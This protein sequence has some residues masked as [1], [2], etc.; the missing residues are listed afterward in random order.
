MAHLSLSLL[1]SF[2]L[3]LDGKPGAGL[4]SNKARALLAYLTVEADRPHRREALAGLLWPD[5]PD[6]DALSNLRYA[7]SNLR[8]VIGDRVRGGSRDAEPPFLLV[9][10]DTLQ[11]NT[12]SDYW[13]D[14]TALT[15]LVEVDKAHPS[16]VDQLQQAVVLYRG[17]FLEGFTVSDSPAF[18]E[19]MLFTRER[20]ARQVSSALHHLAAIYEQRGAY[21]QAQSYAWRQ[22]ELEPWNEAAH[23]QLMRVLALG[24]RRSAALAQYE[25]C[26]RLLAEELD[27]EPSI[28]TTTLYEQIRNDKLKALAPPPASPPDLTARLPQFLEK[29]VSPVDIPVFVARERELAQLDGFLNLALAGQ[30]RVAFVI[31]EAGSGKT[32]LIQEFCRRAQDVHADPST[33][34][35]VAGQ[36][37]IVAGGNCNAYTGIGDPYLPFRE[38]LALLT[39]DVEAKWAAGAITQD[40]AHRLWHT[41]PVAAQALLES[42]PDL[43]ETF[44]PRA[45]LLERAMIYAPDGAEWLTRL[46]ELVGY[47][48]TASPSGISTPQQADLFEQYTKVLQALAQ[49]GPLILVL[50][51]LQ[52]ADLGSISLLFHL[53]RHLAGSWI[54]IVGAYRPEEVALGRDGQRHPLEPVVN[55]FQRDFGNIT[56]NLGQAES[57]GFVESFLDSEPNRLGSTFREMLYRQTGGHPLFTIELLRGLWDRGDLEQDPEGRWI[58]GPALDWESLPARVEAVIA[59]RIGRLAQP[60]RTALRVASVEGEVFTAEVVARVTATD[61]REILGCL[62]NELDRQHRLIRAQ[63]IERVDS[64]LLS[65][66]RFRHIL[67]QKYLYSGLDEVER[68]HLHEQVGTTLEGLYGVQKQA[69]VI[70]VQLALHFQEAGIKKKA[71]PYLH[72]AGDKAVQLSA[73]QEAIAHLT[74]ALDLLM[75]LPDTGGEDH[76][77]ER[78]QQELDLQLSLGKALMGDIPGPEWTNA[79]TR[80]HELCQQTGQMA[81]L[82]RVVGNLAIFHYVRAEHQQARELGEEALSLAQQVRDPLLVMLGHWHLGFIFFGLGEFTTAQTHLKQVI[83]C[84]EPQ[85]HHRLFVSLRGSDA[86]MSALA[87]DACCLWGLGYPEQALQRSQE[88]LV[89]ARELGHPFSLADALCF[90]VCLFNAMRRDAETLNQSAEELKR[91]A[92]DNKLKGWLASGIRYRGEAMIMLG[93]IKEGIAQIRESITVAQFRK[94][95]VDLTGALG[96]LAEARAQTGHLEEGL[97]TLAE[98]LALVEETDERHWEAELY[99]LQGELLLTQ[100][101]KTEAEASLHQAIEVARHQQAKSWELRAAITLSRLWQQQGKQAEAHQILAEIYN[102]FTEGFDTADL[103]EAKA[104]LGSLS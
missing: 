75:A 19:W 64:Q 99:R 1:G 51:D 102:W 97:T 43:I 101:D 55:E 50:D 41:L 83:S 93:Q 73:Y 104:L 66:Y 31:G 82:C 89:L 49:R 24:G 63:S 20:L 9:T 84:Y 67:F 33:L 70:A 54:L 47:K 57:R 46:D 45:A 42:G 53:G 100:G 13:L 28:E 25:S 17:C 18:E 86:G 15:E 61:E 30:G 94:T 3:T 39:G 77:L 76:R 65:R 71:I 2:Q 87:Y 58:E 81:Q 80:A 62:S 38:I 22:I 88:A 27:V 78:A 52:W 40:H 4:K 74:K 35:T 98:A 7:L 90:G 92:N 69:T 32:A 91:L 56:V 34:P 72:Q 37:L 26:R 6:R 8:R 96:F 44:V 103:K 36:A 95:R 16:A 85:H 23:Q 59:E 12:A 60:L 48:P 29:E 68:V 5:W 14:V 79:Y 21:E 10:R 11:F